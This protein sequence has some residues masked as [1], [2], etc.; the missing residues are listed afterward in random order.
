MGAYVREGRK[1]VRLVASCKACGWRGPRAKEVTVPLFMDIHDRVEGATPEDIA[2]AH[3]ADLAAQGAHGVKYLEYWFSP[4]TGRVFCLSEGPSAE[5]VD[6]VHRSS[7]GLAAD[8]IM[9]VVAGS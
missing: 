1:K 4:A 5:V 2:A 3:Q 8:E 6:R 7:H 9:E